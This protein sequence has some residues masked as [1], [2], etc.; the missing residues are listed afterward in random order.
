MGGQTSPAR[1]DPCGLSCSS[2][3][4]SSSESLYKSITSAF[5][6]GGSFFRLPILVKSVDDFCAIMKLN[7][8]SGFCEKTEV[9]HFVSYYLHASHPSRCAPRTTPTSTTFL[10]YSS[11]VYCV[12]GAGAERHVE[13]EAG[14]LAL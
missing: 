6:L 10:V 13:M 7:V 8:D 2:S 3:S 11:C 4:S 14:A 12:I 9:T 5:C 1:V